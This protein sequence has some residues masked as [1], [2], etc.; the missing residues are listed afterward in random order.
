[1]WVGSN[2]TVTPVFMRYPLNWSRHALNIFYCQRKNGLKMTFVCLF[3]TDA[4]KVTMLEEVCS[5]LQNGQ[6]RAPPC[7]RHSLSDF[8]TAI[9]EALQPYSTTKQL[10]ILNE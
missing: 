5:M 3:F 6:L 1:M 2:S 7:K 9:A 4:S 8:K 10:L